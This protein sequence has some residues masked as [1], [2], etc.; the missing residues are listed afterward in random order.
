MVALPEGSV[1]TAGVDILETA[2]GKL[3]LLEANFP[4][5]FAQAQVA[6]GVDIAVMML[7]YLLQKRSERGDA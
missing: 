4:C 3:Y 5:Y 2:D 7:D 6:V 1:P